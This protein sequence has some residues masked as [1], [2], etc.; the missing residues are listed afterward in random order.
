M[1]L[2]Q[3]TFF[4]CNSIKLKKYPFWMLKVATT[5]TAAGSVSPLESVHQLAA[6][7]YRNI[8]V[9]SFF[10]VFNSDT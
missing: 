8:G 2:N 1:L 9:W 7:Q 5:T 3:I 4:S 6:A 10:H